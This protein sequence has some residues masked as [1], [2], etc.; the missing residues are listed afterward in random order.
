MADKNLKKMGRPKLDDSEKRNHRISMCLSAKEVEKLK[1]FGLDNSEKIR[2][3]LFQTFVEKTIILSSKKDIKYIHEL[4]KIGINLNQ[5][6]KILNARQ[7]ISPEN[8][9]KL[10]DILNQ[11]QEKIR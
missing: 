11:I 6:A 8:F 7:G 2:V 9:K 10:D 1:S 3:Y 4:N 5:I